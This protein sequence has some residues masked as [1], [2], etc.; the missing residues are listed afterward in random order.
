MCRIVGC[1]DGIVD[2]GEECDDGN[3]IDN[4]GCTN[5]CTR[6]K[7]GDSIVQTFLGEVCD[8]GIN[9]GTYGHCGF[10]CTYWAPRCGDGVVD[11]LN[12]EACDDG[13]NDGSYGSCTN[14][15][16]FAPRCGDGIVQEGYEECDEGE[17]NGKGTCSANCRVVV[18]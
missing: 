16:Q 14:D 3:G 11:K 15:C 9:D 10:G 17:N 2:A 6:P 8:D 5:A 4:D 18:N 7:C 12:G 1:G 13:L